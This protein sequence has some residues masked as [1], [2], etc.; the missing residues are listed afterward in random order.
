M[1]GSHKTSDVSSSCGCL[2]RKLKEKKSEKEIKKK[3]SRRKN[4]IKRS[5]MNNKAYIRMI[6]NLWQRSYNL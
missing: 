6:G 4:S 2:Q 1:P 5:K 3:N